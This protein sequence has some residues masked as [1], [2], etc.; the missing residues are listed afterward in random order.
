RLHLSRRD[1][2]DAGAQL[3]GAQRVVPEVGRGVGAGEDQHAHLL[4]SRIAVAADHVLP[5]AERL[6]GRARRSREEVH[7][8]ELSYE[9]GRAAGRPG[10]DELLLDQHDPTRLL[11]GEV[12]GEAGAV[13][14]A[15]DD[16]DIRSLRD[17]YHS[18][19]LTRRSGSSDRARSV[20]QWPYPPPSAG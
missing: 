11:A 7:G 18:L 20:R 6:G 10:G 1:E 12:I 19:G 4:E 15:P 13:H 9:G 16:D 3:A 2:R 14:P 5:A 8:V 17:V